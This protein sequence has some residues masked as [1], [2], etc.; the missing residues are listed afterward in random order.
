LKIKNLL[1]FFYS[2]KNES[3]IDI[4]CIIYIYKFFS[5]IYVDVAIQCVSIIRLEFASLN[6]NLEMST[7]C[8]SHKEIVYISNRNTID[9]AR[10]K[11]RKI[12]KTIKRYM[13]TA[14]V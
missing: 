4:G 12:K 6:L 2:K 14:S 5:H 9:A 13:D 3:I 10:L 1:L 11:T 7:R 8:A